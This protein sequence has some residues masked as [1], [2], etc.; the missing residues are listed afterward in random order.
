MLVKDAMVRNV[1]AVSRN[2]SIK[3]LLDIFLLNRIDALPVIDKSDRLVGYVTLDE[4]AEVLMPRYKD[5]IRDYTYLQDYG[6]L[7]QFFEAQSHLLEEER[8]ILVDDCVNPHITTIREND[9]LLTAAAI[10]QSNNIRRLP[11]I[12]TSQHLVGIIS[13]TDILLYLFKRKP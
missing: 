9:P 1:I 2:A 7:E 8:L 11:V 12:D 4:L 13:L 3:K 5:I 6:R 10:M